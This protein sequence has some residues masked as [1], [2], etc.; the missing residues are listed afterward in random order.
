MNIKLYLPLA[1]GAVGLFSVPASAL[2]L[3]ANGSFGTGTYTFDGGGA[4][5]LG[6]GSSAIA[7]WSVVNGELAVISNTNV[8]GITAEDGTT[9]LVLT[10]YHNSS[11]YGGVEQTIATSIGQQ[12]T[13]Q[14]Y[15]GVQN[16]TGAFAEPNSVDAMVNG[17]VIGTAVNN[18]TGSGQQW[19]VA[20]Y[21]FTAT[22]TSTV[23][24]LVGHSSGGGQYIGLDGVSV[25]AVPEPSSLVLAA[26]SVLGLLGFRRRRS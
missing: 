24:D 17:N 22:G 20:S 18:M 11:P 7:G 10:G 6:I 8:W 19:S 14:F 16:G 9:S 4:D 13:L 1:I 2:N 26:G 25:Q 12:Y 3:I 23:V 5:S 15:V 21:S